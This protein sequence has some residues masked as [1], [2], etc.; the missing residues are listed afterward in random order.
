MEFEEKRKICTAYEKGKI[1]K[2]INN[3]DYRVK[4]VKVD[5]CIPNN[6]EKRCDY[7]M[8]IKSINRVIF[9][10]LK[11]GDLTHALKQIHNTIL[12]LKPDFKHY[13]IDA[14][15]VGSKDVPGFINLPYY[16]KLESEIRKTNGKIIRGTNNIYT[17]NI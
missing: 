3:S 2:L 9:I 15:I 14:R 12:H 4:K 5:N 1:F 6:G 7:L 17:E 13:Q 10:E 11:G 16:L 8:E